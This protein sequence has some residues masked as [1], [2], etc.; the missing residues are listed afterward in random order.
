MPESKLS[1]ANSKHWKR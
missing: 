1:H